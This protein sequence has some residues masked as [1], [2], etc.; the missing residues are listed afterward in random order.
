MNVVGDKLF[1]FGAGRLCKR[2]KVIGLY[3]RSNKEKPSVNPTGA[4]DELTITEA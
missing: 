1:K 4:G 3:L 2:S